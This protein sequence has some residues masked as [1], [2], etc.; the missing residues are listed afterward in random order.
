M[1]Q[2]IVIPQFPLGWTTMAVP[3]VETCA[4]CGTSLHQGETAHYY[5]NAKHTRAYCSTCYPQRVLKA[6]HPQGMRRR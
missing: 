1:N 3:F 4:A 2:Y 5:R 6:P